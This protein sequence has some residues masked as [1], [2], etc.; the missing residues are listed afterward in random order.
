MRRVGR[1]SVI[2]L[3]LLLASVPLAARGARESVP[4]AVGDT[5][6]LVGIIGVYGNEPRSYLAILVNQDENEGF[7]PGPDV[8]YMP[9]A[10]ET[11]RAAEYL[12]RLAGDLTEELRHLQRRT[13]RIVGTITERAIGPGFPAVI[14]VE[15]YV[16]V[17]TR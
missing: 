11:E 17:R 7:L 10:D 6:E 3:L 12:F 4:A 5:V 16:E 9:D 8:A 15:S 13:V 1:L 14:E 2:P